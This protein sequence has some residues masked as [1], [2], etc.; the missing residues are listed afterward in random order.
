M[1]RNIAG[2]VKETSRNRQGTAWAGI[3]QEPSRNRQG[4]AWAGIL[5]EPSRDQQAQKHLGTD[6]AAAKA[7][8]INYST[9]IITRFFEE[10]HDDTDYNQQPLLGFL[11]HFLRTLKEVS[12][13]VLNAAG[14]CAVSHCNNRSRCTWSISSY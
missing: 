8:A 7:G 5:Q 13:S 1:G 4:T 11:L 6:K 9:G 3:L 10:H 2:T 14:L 12:L